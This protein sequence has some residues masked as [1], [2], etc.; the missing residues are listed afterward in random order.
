MNKRYIYCCK[1]CWYIWRN[2]KKYSHNDQN[3]KYYELNDNG[4]L[5]YKGY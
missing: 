4:Y 3:D 1:K 5:E 2:I